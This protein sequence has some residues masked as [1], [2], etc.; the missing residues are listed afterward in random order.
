MAQVACFDRVL[1]HQQPAL[2]SD[3]RQGG[4]LGHAMG[5]GDLE[6]EFGRVGEARRLLLELGGKEETRRYA[7][8]FRRRM[9]RRLVGLEVERGDA[10]HRIGREVR[11]V[12]GAAHQRDHFARRDTALA[13]DADGQDRRMQGERAALGLGRRDADGARLRPTP[14]AG[15]RPDLID[16]RRHQALV[17]LERDRLRG[18]ERGGNGF[19]RTRIGDAPAVRR[20]VDGDTDGRVAAGGDRRTALERL[21]DPGGQAIGAMVAAEQRHDRT[22]VAADRDQRRLVALVLEQRR[23]RAQ[24]DTGG[25]DADHRRAALEQRSQMGRGVGEGLIAARH[26]A[27]AAVQHGTWQRAHDTLGGLGPGT[28]ERDNG[29]LRRGRF[30]ARHAPLRRCTRIIEK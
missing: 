26:A 15:R 20:F 29:D 4:A 12:E 2:A 5:A 8:C 18:Q 6:D 30:H 9:H 23:H 19:R 1:G 7:E 13:A 17:N 25:T 14:S 3:R 21:R 22:S 11:L 16:P 10:G 27:G 24:Q 28:R